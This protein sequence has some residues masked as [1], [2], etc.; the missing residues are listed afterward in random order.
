MM[1]ILLALKQ[2]SV[3]GR[4]FVSERD[5]L[6]RELSVCLLLLVKFLL[7]QGDFRLKISEGLLVVDS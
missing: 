2:L 5:Y 3:H 1:H 7:E 4:D 6:L